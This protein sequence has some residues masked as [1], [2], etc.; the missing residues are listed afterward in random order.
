MSRVVALNKEICVHYQSSGLIFF[1]ILTSVIELLENS[2]SFISI[3]ETGI[4]SM[5]IKFVHLHYKLK[6]SRMSAP[7]LHIYM[8]CIVTSECCKQ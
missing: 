4:S 7:E 3:M 5:D 1:I 8:R 6:L 2:V